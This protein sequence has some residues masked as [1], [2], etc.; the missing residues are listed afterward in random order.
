MKHCSIKCAG[1]TE[2]IIPTFSRIKVVLFFFILISG[3]SAAAQ[4]GALYAGAEQHS[5]RPLKAMDEKPY[6]GTDIPVSGHEKLMTYNQLEVVNL[7]D[8]GFPA[9]ERSTNALITVGNKVYGATSGDKCHIFRFD[10]HTKTVTS[11]AT[12]EGPNTILKG[13]VLDGSTLYIGTMLTRSQLWWE[14]RRRGGKYEELDA[15]LYQIDD[16]WNTGHLYR[17]T[18]ITGDHPEITDLGIPVKGQGINT[19]AID[20]KR[21]LIYGITYPLGRFF[22]YDIKS[23][24]TET[25]TFGTT[26]S[27]VSN[28][29]VL[30][31]EVTKDLTDFIPG[32]LESMGKLPARAMHVM[33]NGILYTSGW[34]GCILKY[35]PSI[36]KPEDRFS[37]AG[38]LPCVPGRQYWNR[39]DEII[40]R[41]GKLWMGTSDGYIFCFNP[42]TNEVQNY[43]KPIRAIETM[44]LAFSSKDG[45]LYGLSGGDLEG[46]T[47]FWAFD[48]AVHAFE[49]DYPAVQGFAKKPM[50]DI[51]CTEDGT[52][53]I[54]ETGRV[55]NIW[56][57]S[58]GKPGK[59][60]KS[61][62]L[63][64]LNVVNHEVPDKL[65][66]HT[67]KIEAEVYPIPSEMHGGSGYTAIEFDR[68]GKLYVGTANYGFTASLVQLDPI[69]HTWRR[70][71]RSD[72]LTH[73]FAR[74]AGA[75]GKIHTKL[76][77]GADG[78]I[79]GGMKQGFEF[80]FNSRPDEGESPEGLRG[81]VYTT[82]FFSFDPKTNTALDLGP[83]YRGNGMVSF[84][85][86]TKR[87]HLYAVSDPSMHFMVYDLKTKRV[88]NAGSIA[89]TAPAR[90]MAIDEETGRVYHPGEVTPE[91][92]QFMT[93]WDPVEF[94]LRDYE[95][96]ADDGLKYRHS[97]TITAGP[98][99]SRKLYGA[100]WSPDV[101]EMD[102][103]T[104]IDGKLHVKR[105]CAVSVEGESFPGYMNCITL[106]PDGRL[107]WAV[108]YAEEGP[109]A[110]FAWDPKVKKRTYIGTLT[111]GG[112]WLKNAVLQGIA[113]DPQGNLAIT[114]LYLKLTPDQIKLAHWQP[115]TQYRDFENKPYYLG[116]P[117]WRKGTYYSVVYIKGATKIR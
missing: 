3:L 14:G 55:A 56:V 101:W 89:G 17:I 96:V 33:S 117:G 106:G 77:L 88:W 31:A 59:W 53:V 74:G 79:Y 24:K 19:M 42:A 63:E 45:Q 40:E 39:L 60:T 64:E 70:I 90:Y 44:G 86:D 114:T 67:K 61:G 41:D 92:K 73:Q 30:F 49:V 115:G 54:A 18:G 34:D 8:Q 20:A 35:D 93:V 102:L 16:S 2:T 80:M 29:M 38:Y 21:G 47:R 98:K 57:L 105:I 65:G 103:N 23:G 25:I 22:I 91:G 104:G 87:D 76:R 109:I 6:A 113:L 71:F 36:A 1:I 85:A 10:P 4:H 66:G 72:E 7:R 81:S 111:S 108:S 95:I 94:R 26:R 46:V 5:Y 37:K 48:P 28:S 68:D 11:L 58:P 100:N 12:I 83:G 110:V 107:Y 99:G 9:D 69:K 116:T 84:C 32:E 27:Q 52:M 51:V 78:K 112:A 13:M 15:N 50:S 97:Y 43:G 82:H 75:P 62:E